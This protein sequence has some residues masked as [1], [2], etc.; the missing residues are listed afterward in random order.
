MPKLCHLTPKL[1]GVPKQ[2]IKFFNFVMTLF[3]GKTVFS[4]A[5][6][7]SENPKNRVTYY[8]DVPLF[9]RIF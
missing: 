6:I 4:K 9:I 3:R 1:V 2:V 8:V 7:M 5:K